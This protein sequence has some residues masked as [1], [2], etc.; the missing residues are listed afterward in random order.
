MTIPKFTLDRQVGLNLTAEEVSASWNKIER[1][2]D[3]IVGMDALYNQV[4]AAEEKRRAMHRGMMVFSFGDTPRL[5]SAY[6][7]WYAINACR[8]FKIIAHLGNVFSKPGFK[9]AK[10]RDDYPGAVC[11]AVMV[12]RNK[13]AAHYSFTDRR[14]DD[15]QADIEASTISNIAWFDDRYFAGLMKSILGRGTNT[16]RSQHK[17][18][19]S[20]TQFHENQVLARVSPA[21][22]LMLQPV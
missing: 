9:T 14:R 19:W 15:N 22:L 18:E 21:D 16:Y 7:D 6:F 12:W 1:L 11:G 13:I 5:F 2:K 10:H 17:Y 4:R 8:T 20:L 3:L